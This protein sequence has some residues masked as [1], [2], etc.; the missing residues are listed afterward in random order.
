VA[1]SGDVRSP[2]SFDWREGITLRN[3][4]LK[5]GGLRASARDCVWGHRARPTA[6]AR[7]SG[8]ST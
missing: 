1:V 8:P 5:A 4:M 2:E 6:S 3:L 7:Q